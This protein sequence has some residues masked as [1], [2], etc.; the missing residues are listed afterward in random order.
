MELLAPAGTPEA[1]KSAVRNGADAIAVGGE[2]LNARRAAPGFGGEE[3]RALIAYCHLRN[4]KVHVAVNIL[5]QEEE[6]PLLLKLAEGL[7]A[8]GADAAI[9]S[10][11]GVA[12]VLR[13]VCPTL[14]LHAST[15]LNIHSV[16]GVRLMEELGFS[17]VVLAR[18]LSLAEIAEICRSTRAEI[19]VFAHGALCMCYS[20]I[21][22]Y[23]P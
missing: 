9:V 4:V 14:P 20:G 10:D 13:Q 12:R 2:G 18:E 22:I 19:E 8:S 21:A 3:L 17:R 16:S 15:Q 1:V 5:T 6:L 11:L 23:P 7:A